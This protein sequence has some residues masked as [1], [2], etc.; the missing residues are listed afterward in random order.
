MVDSNSCD[1]TTDGYNCCSKRIIYNADGMECGKVKLIELQLKEA[2]EFNE[3]CSKCCGRKCGIVE[4]SSDDF[5]HL[6][7]WLKI[8]GVGDGYVAP[9]EEKLI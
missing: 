6:I 3:C 1:N 7:E 9:T 8:K 5:D 4:I 2:I